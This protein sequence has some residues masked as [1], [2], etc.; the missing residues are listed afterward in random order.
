MTRESAI[1]QLKR[2]KMDMSHTGDEYNAIMVAIK[3]LEQEPC[4][5]AISRADAIKAVTTMCEEYTP[6]K[7]T[8]H[9]HID[10]VVEEL[11]K[12][13]PITPTPQ[14]KTGHWIYHEEKRFISAEHW[15][16][17][18]C[19]RTTMIYPFR[20]DGNDYDAMYY[21]PKCGAKMIEKEKEE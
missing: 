7:S 8:Y 20:V 18:W 9:P 3:A 11:N 2:M 6:T 10:F 21:C 17:S 19:H 12:L 1:K 15:E 13:P 4:D 16:C 14:P 5:D